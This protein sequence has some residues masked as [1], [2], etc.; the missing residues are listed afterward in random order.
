MVL[1]Q[2]KSVFWA[3][4]GK[5]GLRGLQG[6]LS[7]DAAKESGKRHGVRAL[8]EGG[9]SLKTAVRR[10]GRSGVGGTAPPPGT[11]F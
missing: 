10:V 6:R 7:K 2:N 9:F 8:T 11:P 1:F 5:P 4:E 3:P